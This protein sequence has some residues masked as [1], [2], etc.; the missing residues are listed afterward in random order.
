MREKASAVTMSRDAVLWSC[1]IV[2]QQG[3]E[4]A[5]AGEQHVAVGLEEPPLHQ[6]AA[7][8]EV[9]ALALLVELPQQLGQLTDLALTSVAGGAAMEVPCYLAKLLR[10][11]NEQRKRD[12][13]CDCSVLVE[14]RLFK[15]HRNVLFAGSGYFRALLVHYLQVGAPGCRR[16]PVRTHLSPNLPC[17]LAKLLRELNEQRKRDYFCDCSVLVEGRLFKAHRNVLFAGSGYFRALLVHYLQRWTSGRREKVLELPRGPGGNLWNSDGGT[18]AERTLGRAAIKGEPPCTWQ[19]DSVVEDEREEEEEGEEEKLAATWTRF[20]SQT[21]GKNGKQIE[22]SRL[23]LIRAQQR[24]A[25]K[26]SK[27]AL[28][29]PERDSE[30][31]T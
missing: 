1:P 11:L 25:L 8:A 20:V 7:V 2:H 19:R 31:R 16:K 3:P 18:A 26:G 9:V 29:P 21:A 17:Y 12:Y 23:T 6:D 24:R 5:A 27:R 13:F 10:E 14:G 30:R 15:A 4:V 28:P 22:V